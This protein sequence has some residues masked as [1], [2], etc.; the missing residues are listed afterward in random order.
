MGPE[1]K[2]ALEN[3]K[4][5]GPFDPA[6]FGRYRDAARWIET[7]RLLHR[8]TCADFAEASL[9]AGVTLSQI[10]KDFADGAPQSNSASDAE[11]IAYLGYSG[12]ICNRIR[13]VASLRVVSSI[14]NIKFVWTWAENKACAG[15]PAYIHSRSSGPS[16][17]LQVSDM[18]GFLEQASGVLIETFPGSAGTFHKKYKERLNDITWVDFTSLYKREVAKVFNEIILVQPNGPQEIARIK[19]NIGGDYVAAHVRRTDFKK[20]IEDRYP[21][22]TLP[23]VRNYVDAARDLAPDCPVWLST[24]D[25]AVFDQFQGEWR[26]G[27]ILRYEGEFVAGKLRQTSFWHSIV[28]LA[29]LGGAAAAV[30]TPHSSFSDFVRGYSSGKSVTLD[31]KSF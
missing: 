31:L 29:M 7:A 17:Y 12:G 11:T 23:D 19:S 2:K 3:A 21:G 27:D 26:G 5:I 18:I 16:D 22:K 15:G 8:Y 1:L 25:A 30:L 9:R 20:H 24:D 4:T 28:D 6:A 10:Q 14:A 13:T